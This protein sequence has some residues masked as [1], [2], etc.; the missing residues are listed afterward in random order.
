VGLVFLGTLLILLACDAEA[1][2][3][4]P[5]KDSKVSADLLEM[6]EP[7]FA[8]RSAAVTGPDVVSEE[9]HET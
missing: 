4:A 5:P 6:A 8:T 1:A 7:A 9:H 3:I 2:W